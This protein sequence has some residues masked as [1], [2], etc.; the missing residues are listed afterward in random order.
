MGRVCFRFLKASTIAEFSFL[1]FRRQ[2]AVQIIL[3]R[4][5]SHAEDSEARL[6]SWGRELCQL[7]EGPVLGLMLIS[8]LET[9]LL[10]GT[11]THIFYFSLN[12]ANYETDPSLT[13]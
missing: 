3:S 11:R 2:V 6:A 4:P 12:P 13:C 10:F 8:C 5:D 9:P 7:F 1:T